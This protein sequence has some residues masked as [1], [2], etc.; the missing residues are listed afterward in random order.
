MM[1]SRRPAY[2]VFCFFELARLAITFTVLTPGH[3]PVPSPAL[4]FSAAQAIFPILWLFLFLDSRRYAVY[5][6]LGMAGKV[7]SLTSLAAW[8]FGS[9]REVSLA[10]AVSDVQSALLFFSVIGAFLLDALLLVALALLGRA[11]KGSEASS[12]QVASETSPLEVD[13]IPDSLSEGED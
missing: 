5:R 11:D 2:L 6:P 4:A 3:T 1:T 7:I 9:Q 10:L 13:E 8:I 12:V